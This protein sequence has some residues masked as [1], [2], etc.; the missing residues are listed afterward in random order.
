MYT[1]TFSKE[2]ARQFALDIFDQLV[3][4][5]REQDQREQA[6]ATDTEKEVA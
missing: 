2:M 4:D 3:Q 5:I 1:V 6:E